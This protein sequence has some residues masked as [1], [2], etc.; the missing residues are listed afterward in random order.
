MTRSKLIPTQETTT[1]LTQ[2]QIDNIS[3]DLARVIDQR[4]NPGFIAGMARNYM[5]DSDATIAQLAK[6]MVERGADINYI[7]IST[8]T[9]FIDCLNNELYDIIQGFF[10]AGVRDYIPR[11]G[12]IINGQVIPGKKADSKSIVSAV[13][14]MPYSTEREAF[15]E[16]AFSQGAEIAYGRNNDVIRLDHAGNYTGGYGHDMFV[17]Y[18][19]FVGKEN[20]GKIYITDLNFGGYTDYINACACPPIRYDNNNSPLIYSEGSSAFVFWCGPAQIWLLGLSS[21][22]FD[23]VAII[24]NS[25]CMFDHDEF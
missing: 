5:Q 10:D 12:S 3:S 4:D 17:L 19:D 11:T 21:S 13:V 23:K 14:E 18:R 8:N 16:H 7:F 25:K 20:G 6:T 9:I 15:L 1:T 2:Q 24:Q 22:D